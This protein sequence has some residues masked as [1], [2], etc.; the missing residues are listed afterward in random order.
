MVTISLLGRWMPLSTTQHYWTKRKFLQYA[1]DFREP[2]TILGTANQISF[3]RSLNYVSDVCVCV[4]V[5]VCVHVCVCLCV[6]VRMY[7]CV[8]MSLCVCVCVCVCVYVRAR[9]CVQ[10]HA[11]FVCICAHVCALLC[12]CVCMYTF[13]TVACVSVLV[14]I[15]T[16]TILIVFCLFSTFL[17][18]KEK[19]KKVKNLFIVSSRQS[20]HSNYP[21]VNTTC[22]RVSL[23]NP[24]PN[25]M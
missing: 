7:V 12:E 25:V 16:Y 10:V 20:F 21:Y 9:A 3:N 23:L 11:H 8:C 22:D 19:W 13:L 24:S 4:C 15:C 14:C 5:C 6:C 18:I 17:D 1:R 2:L